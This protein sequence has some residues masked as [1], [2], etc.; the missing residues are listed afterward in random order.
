MMRSNE[1][2]SNAAKKVFESYGI[3]IQTE[4]DVDF[5]NRYNSSTDEVYPVFVDLTDPKDVANKLNISVETLYEELS[6][7]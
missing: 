7:L 6:E 4:G 1:I 3:E 2:D 5:F